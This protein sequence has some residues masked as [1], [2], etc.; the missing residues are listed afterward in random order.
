M[1]RTS[2][3]YSLKA[4][5]WMRRLNYTVIPIA[6]APF[7]VEFGEVKDNTALSTH[8]AVDRLMLTLPYQN[9]RQERQNYRLFAASIYLSS[10]PYPKFSKRSSPLQTKNRS[11]YNGASVDTSAI[12]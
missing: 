3:S 5:D 6:I 9:R 10:H 12:A 8:W 1:E 4:K 2:Q 11:H 7:I